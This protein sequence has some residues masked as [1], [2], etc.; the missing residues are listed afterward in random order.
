[1]EQSGGQ[2]YLTIGDTIRVRLPYS[3]VCVHMRVAGKPMT[4]Q[5]VGTEYPVA[6]LIGDDGAPF[7]GPIL[8]G[9]AGIYT[10]GERYYVPARSVVPKPD[11]HSL[12]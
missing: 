10:D 12:I 6:Q 3:E 1:M 8:L 4:V 11:S 5:I 2:V 9:E 7:S